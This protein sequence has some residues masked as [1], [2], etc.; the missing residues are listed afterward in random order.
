MPA[1]EVTTPSCQATQ[2]FHNHCGH[3]VTTFTHHSDL[4][5]RKQDSRPSTSSSAIS[6]ASA[7]LQRSASSAFKGM[8]QNLGKLARRLT[9]R[10]SQPQQPQTTSQEFT[11]TARV[12]CPQVLYEPLY[13]SYP[14]PPCAKAMGMGPGDLD[15]IFAGTE[16]EKWQQKKEMLKAKADGWA[17]KMGEWER[18]VRVPKKDG[19]S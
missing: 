2:T 15:K 12:A 18:G 4:C 16:E 8:G 13:Q 14:C 5:V 9:L 19:S 3:T 6:N 7:K 17:A 1:Q 10:S 11:F